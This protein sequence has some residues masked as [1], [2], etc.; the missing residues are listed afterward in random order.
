MLQDNN[1]DAACMYEMQREGVEKEQ[2]CVFG[3]LLCAGLIDLCC[4]VLAVD[5]R[6][7]KLEHTQKKAQKNKA[8]KWEQKALVGPF[9]SKDF[10]VLSSLFFAHFFCFQVLFFLQLLEC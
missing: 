5:D 6:R 7:Q 4:A 2:C 10:L 9:L 1:P 8:K 3:L